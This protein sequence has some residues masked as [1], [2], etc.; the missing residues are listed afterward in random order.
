M[1]KGQN[2]FKRK[3][4]RWEARYIKGRNPDGK[5]RYGFCYGKTYKIAKE[6]A[7][8]ARMAFKVQV[9]TEPAAKRRLEHYCDEWLLINKSRYKASTLVKYSTILEKHIKPELGALELSALT[10][11]AIES[12]ASRLSASLAPKT[13]RDILSVLK[14]VLKYAARHEPESLPPIDIVYPKEERGETRV[15]SMEEQRRLACY[16]AADMDS[17]RF[18][19]L[20]ALL[21]GLRIGELCALK[22]GD[23]SLDEGTLKVTRT[24]Q[25]LKNLDGDADSKTKVVI[26]GTKTG[27]STRVIPMSAYAL[28]LC[29]KMGECAPEHYVLTGTERCME[30]RTLQYRLDVYTKA[31][32]LEGVHFHT[33]RHSFATR[34]IE[35]GFEIKS[36]REILGHASTTIT[37]ERYA[38]SSM[39]LKRKNMDKLSRIGL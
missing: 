39:R 5:L 15:L 1:R 26:G 4:G 13:V 20:L 17:C 37:L 11:V 6:K 33:L 19:V 28:E 27:S 22:W 2:I 8:M 7:A 30:P 38:H 9:P 36:L 29:R 16:L 18:G 12:F 23:I 31:C 35:N 14:S 3:D 25:R 21:T 10:S 32:G 24:V 34:C